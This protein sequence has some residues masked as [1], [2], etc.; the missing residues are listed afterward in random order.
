[1]SPLFLLSLGSS[2]LLAILVILV[3]IVLY[4]I[5][6]QRSLIRLQE[7]TKNTLGQIGVQVNSRWDALTQLAKATVAYAKHE[8]DTLIDLIKERRASTI[9]QTI[10]SINQQMHA[11]NSVLDRLFA[12]AENYPDLKA[13]TVY[14]DMMAS[15]D[16]YENNVRLQRMV[17]N[18]AATRLNNM[19][20]MF[21]SN[22]VARM[23]GFSTIDYFAADVEKTAMPDLNL[24]R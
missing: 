22:L 6:I 2:I 15:I 12:L 23:L 8:H 14:Q 20:R 4:V 16:K 10:E 11:T 21:P 24:E 3:L 7:M 13:N 1:M 9:P 19:V 18:D 17:Y 5:S